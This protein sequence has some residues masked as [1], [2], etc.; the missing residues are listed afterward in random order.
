MKVYIS[1]DIEGTTCTTHWDETEHKKTG[2]E[3]GREQMTA[4]VVAACEGLQEAGVTDIWI[5][6]AHASGRNLLA[7]K[8]PEETRLVRGWSGHPF[9]M[10]QELDESFGALLLVG[11]HSRAGSDANPLAHT[12]TGR[13]SL[14]RINDEYVSEFLLHAYA[15][16][17]RGVPVVFVSGDEGLCEDVKRL[18]PH[19]QTVGVKR[20]VG[21]STI[22]IHPRLAVE[23]IKAGA[24]EAVRGDVSR[25]VLPLPDS[26]RVEVTYRKHAEAYRNAF[27]PGAEQTGPYTIRFETNDYFEVM[28]LVLFVV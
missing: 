14:V 1:A 18:T 21:G 25:C 11:Y 12:M 4:E 24:S 13:V 3:A 16:A 23:K 28:R 22:S 2:Y 7:S 6:D 15:A 8:L 17:Y 5:K 27:F 10:V 9:S 19:T 20:G 26:F